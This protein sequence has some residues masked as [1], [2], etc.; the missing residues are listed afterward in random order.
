MQKNKRGGQSGNH[1]A[2]KP[3]SLRSI[4]ALEGVS[5]ETLRKRLIKLGITLDEYVYQKI[6]PKFS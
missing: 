4:A 1:N 5:Y 3:L 6:K 2:K